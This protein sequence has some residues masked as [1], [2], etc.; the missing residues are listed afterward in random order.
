MNFFY[1]SKKN[2]T[3]TNIVGLKVGVSL[4]I[5]EGQQSLWEN[6]IFQNCY[7][8]VELLKCS[9]AISQVFIVNGGPGDP[10]SAGDFLAQAP[11]PVISLS[12]AHDMLD[13]IIELSAQLDPEWGKSFVGK[14]GRIIGMHVANDYII[15]AERMVFGLDPGFRMTAVPYHEIWTLPSFEKTCADYYRV[16]L[17]APVRV[18]PHLWGAVL[19]ERA[20]AAKEEGR[21]FEYRPGRAR[22]RLAILEPN[23]CS[24][25]TC[26]LPMLLSDVAHRNDPKIIEYV[27]VYNTLRLKEHRDFVAYARSLDIVKQGLATFEGRYPIFDIMGQDSDAIISHHWENAQN[28]LYYE[29]LYGGFPLIHNSNLLGDCGYIYRSFDPE[30]G[31]LALLQAFAEHDRH[32]D[33][34]RAD[35]NRFLATLA[36]NNKEN[37]AAFE[38]AILHVCG[39]EVGA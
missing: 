13:V 15:D 30:D 16:G 1:S 24:V 31:A 28:Y 39:K 33:K 2:E 5:R 22:W 12:E 25:K 3:S 9:A 29:A 8:L 6:G 19:L 35:A 14:S 34:Y 17:R 11:A 27:R 20:L 26:H 4:Y 21:R 38:A 32:L 7:F 23:I 37:I 36:P 18:M 10:S